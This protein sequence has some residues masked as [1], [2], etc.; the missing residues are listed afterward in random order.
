M[1]SEVYELDILTRS[2]LSVIL[3]GI[4]AFVFALFCQ[5]LKVLAQI[6]HTRL[7]RAII[8]RLGSGKSQ[9]RSG[10]GNESVRVTHIEG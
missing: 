7:P 8:C 9:S 2:P 3:A 6:K 1:L 5:H 4:T 10:K